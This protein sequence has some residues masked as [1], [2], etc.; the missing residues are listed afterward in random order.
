[1]RTGR[2]PDHQTAVDPP[3]MGQSMSSSPGQEHEAAGARFGSAGKK[4]TSIFRV[5]T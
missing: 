5:D 4:T 1:M 2:L 3:G